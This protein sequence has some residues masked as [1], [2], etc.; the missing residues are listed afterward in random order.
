MPPCVDQICGFGVDNVFG[1]SMS[2]VVF[3]TNRFSIQFILEQNYA[4]KSYISLCTQCGPK[5]LSKRWFVL[6]PTVTF[7]TLSLSDIHWPLRFYVAHI[8]CRCLH[9]NAWST[10]WGSLISCGGQREWNTAWLKCGHNKWQIAECW[11]HCQVN[12]C[13]WK[14]RNS[15]WEF[16][17]VYL[18][19]L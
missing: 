13:Y 8:H 4:I 1:I 18:I 6:R 14:K 17:C 2:P 7:I 19:V 5:V 11:N 15:F 16:V 9:Q 12:W 10:T 3:V